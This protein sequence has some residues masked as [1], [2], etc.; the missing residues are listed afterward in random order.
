MRVGR[1]SLTLSKDLSTVQP[2]EG[3]PKQTTTMG[4][5]C[6]K[7]GP[8]LGVPS[9]A[10]DQAMLAVRATVGLDRLS[11]GGQPVMPLGQL[12][13]KR[14]LSGSLHDSHVVSHF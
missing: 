4:F 10:T 6:V 3:G 2:G 11:Q 9:F 8:T 12:L 14:G 7:H 13:S 5:Q 1:L